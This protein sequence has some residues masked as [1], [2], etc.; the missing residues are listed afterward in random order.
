MGRRPL[1]AVSGSR[2]PGA[3]LGDHVPSGM[4]ATTFDMASLGFAERLA[5]LGASTVMLPTHESSVEV[6]EHVDGLI[7]SGGADVDPSNYGAPPDPLL[8]AV[9]KRRDRVELAMVRR[10]LEIDLPLLG[11]CRGLHVINVAFGGTLHQHIST[12]D[13]HNVGDRATE[14]VHPVATKGDGT[15]AGLYGDATMVNSLHHQGVQH[16]GPGLRVGAVAPDGIVEAL[17]PTDPA[18]ALLAVQWHP[19]LLGHIDPCFEWLVHASRT[20][21]PSH[22][23]RGT[24]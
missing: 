10:S 22:I 4:A 18:L 2:I 24:P 16:L 13:D 7:L 11:V 3:F 23:D 12:A 8:G 19:E 5:E 14:G 17:E 21:R 9:D 20:H 6:L 1:I 15:T